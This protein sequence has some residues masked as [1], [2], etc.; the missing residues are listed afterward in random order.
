M[1]NN[2]VHFAYVNLFH[3]FIEAYRHISFSW[4]EKKKERL[5]RIELKEN[6][7]S[8]FCR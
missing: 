6:C 2:I 8:L 4:S 1:S 5:K 7:E 3:L